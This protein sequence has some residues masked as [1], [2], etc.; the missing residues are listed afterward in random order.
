M[1]YDVSQVLKN[2]G[3]SMELSGEIECPEKRIA[4][5]SPVFKNLAFKGR[6]TNIGGVLELK[7]STSGSYVVLCSRCA[8]EIN[9]DLKKDF[10]EILVNSDTA[11]Y[12]DKDDAVLFEGHSVDVSEIVTANILLS[13]PSVFLCSEDCRGLCHK[14]GADLNAEQCG[15][16]DDETDPRWDALKNFVIRE[17]E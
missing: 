11:D 10:T 5:A 9:A 14:C 13:L 15:C 7:V 2:F 3:E 17:S 6:I 16:T 1:L 8:K 4:G 12:E